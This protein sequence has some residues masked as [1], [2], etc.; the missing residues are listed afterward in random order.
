MLFTIASLACSLADSIYLLVV[1]RAFQ[2]IGGGA[3]MPTATGIVAE[4]FGR[5]RD[6]AVGMF[7][8]IFP[9]GGILGPI[10]GGIIVT[11]WSRGQIFIVNVPAGLLLILLAWRFIPPSAPKAAARI[12]GVG[13]LL[14]ALTIL[15]GMYGISSLGGSGAEPTDPLFIA[16]MALALTLGVLFVRHANRAHGAVHPDQPAARPRLRG[17]EHDQLPLRRGHARVSARSS[18]CTPSR[19]TGSSRSRRERC[20]RQGPSG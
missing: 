20:S 14:L 3:F 15:F 11:Y 6:R 5:D 7:T 16:S 1:F 4:Q 12:D 10:V 19:G 18:R 8:S 2:A 13:A 17:D 9:I